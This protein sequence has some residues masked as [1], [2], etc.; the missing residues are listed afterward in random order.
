M[1][2]C[3]PKLAWAS[4][5]VR[6]E[7]SHSTRGDRT[8]RPVAASPVFEHP[9]PLLSIDQMQGE[10]FA[11]MKRE[12]PDLEKGMFSFWLAQN[13][14]SD[15]KDGMKVDG[16]VITLGGYDEDYFEGEISWVPISK[17]WY[18]QVEVDAV[19]VDGKSLSENR[20][21]AIVDTG[22][23]LILGSE[24]EVAE[25]YTRLDLVGQADEY[26]EIVKPCDEIKVRP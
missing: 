5:G 1:I 13:A 10:L 19:T 3:R 8:P 9:L 2:S 20:H 23:S 22:T 18:W 26:G 25:L 4:P 24:R 17:A 21:T 14:N 11:G 6:L 12:N 7:C 16:G 15:S